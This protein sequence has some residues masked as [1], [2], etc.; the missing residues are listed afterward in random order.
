M[1]IKNID[2]IGK[3]FGILQ[4]IGIGG[5]DDNNKRLMLCKCLNHLNE[6]PHYV[7]KT[8]LTTGK[9]TMCGLCRIESQTKHGMWNTKTYTAFNNM[10]KRI[11]NPKNIGY[12]NYG[13]RGIDMDPKYNPLFE[14]QGT[15]KAFKNFLKDIGEIPEGLT[16]DR[17][18][19]DKGYWKENIRLVSQEV[20]NQNSRSATL[21][22]KKVKQMRKDYSTGRFTYKTIAEKYNISV[23]GA[24]KVLTNVTWKN[25]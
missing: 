9:T 2:M 8:F 25:V 23:S 6:N 3:I 5:Y 12:K 10:L 21:D 22:I 13:G 17:K 15:E 11:T 1:K 7:R 24:S 4:V 19:N 14:N 16:L 18:N 20:Q